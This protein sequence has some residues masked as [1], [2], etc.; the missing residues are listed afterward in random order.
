MNAKAAAAWLVT[1]TGSARQPTPES[2]TLACLLAP[3]VEVQAQISFIADNDD[4]TQR[5]EENIFWR[6]E[7]TGSRADTPHAAISVKKDGWTWLFGV[8]DQFR[9]GINLDT[10]T[11][12]TYASQFRT[13]TEL[14]SKPSTRRDVLPEERVKDQLRQFPPYSRPGHQDNISLPDL[15]NKGRT[16]RNLEC[17]GCRYFKAEVVELAARVAS[18]PTLSKSE[19]E[20]KTKLEQCLFRDELKNPSP[21]LVCQPATSLLRRIEEVGYAACLGDGT[22]ENRQLFVTQPCDIC[23]PPVNQKA[24]SLPDE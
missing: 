2:A 11:R 20:A 24:S 7:H 9:K 22:A 18:A 5:S 14:I 23:P 10:S 13:E 16:T 1:A 15:F 12:Q 21:N 4:V 6:S 19:V 3:P 17:T 8:V